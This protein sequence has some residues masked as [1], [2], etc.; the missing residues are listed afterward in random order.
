MEITR[1]SLYPTL[2]L[3]PLNVEVNLLKK[4]L[5]SDANISDK[6][7]RIMG[8]ANIKLT[9]DM[10]DKLSQLLRNFISHKSTELT[11]LWSIRKSDT[12]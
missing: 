4:M 12:F 3:L 10:V 8:Q 5:T 9:P 7:T 11:K 2:H 6:V 1:I